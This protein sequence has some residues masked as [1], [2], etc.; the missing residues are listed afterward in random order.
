MSY[1]GKS[2]VKKIGA[3][4]HKA[5]GIAKRN[6]RVLEK[7]G[8]TIDMARNKRMKVAVVG[9]H[10]SVK[11]RIIGRALEKANEINIPEEK[12]HLGTH[13]VDRD[14]VL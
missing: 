10:F 3:I 5:R 13:K 9:K 14:P 6:I 11:I 2:A 7:Q 4:Q 12:L 8:E 1:K